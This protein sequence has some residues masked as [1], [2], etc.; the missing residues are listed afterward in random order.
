MIGKF[1]KFLFGADFGANQ[2]LPDLG[3]RELLVLEALWE[4]GDATAQ[5]IKRRMPDSHVSLSTVQSTLERLNRK[6]LV[7][8]I[9]QGR[10]YSYQTTASR[11]QLI[12][13]LLREMAQ[14]VAGGDMAPMISGFLDYISK[15]APDQIGSLSQ[16]I[17]QRRSRPEHSEVDDD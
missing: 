1:P 13:S 16:S 3:E 14:H 9:K 7:T 6:R 8:R 15:E 5:E 11:S 2:K 10:A 17:G 4:R 12:S